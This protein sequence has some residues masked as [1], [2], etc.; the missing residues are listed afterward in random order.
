ML[1]RSAPAWD[2]VQKLEQ[3]CAKVLPST[4]Q[5][6]EIA[7]DI[8]LHNIME[9]IPA[10]EDVDRYSTEGCI[11]DCD[12]ELTEDEI[13]HL[14][15]SGDEIVDDIKDSETRDS[16]K[17]SHEEELNAL[18]IHSSSIYWGTAGKQCK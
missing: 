12:Q 13:G 6:D 4:N 16:Q 11:D 7:D 2:A 9:Q 3:L 8:D 17:V 10:C 15:N 18:E 5:S 14:V 1:L